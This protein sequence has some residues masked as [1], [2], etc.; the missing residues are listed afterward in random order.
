MKSLYKTWLL[1][2]LALTLPQM[3]VAYQIPTTPSGLWTGTGTTVPATP[4]TKD[5]P[6]GLRT[7]VSL[8]GAA[9]T[10]SA[11]NDVSLM[12]T[13]NTTVPLLPTN[14]NG[15]QVLATVGGGGCN[16]TSLTCT[17]LGTMTI[18]FSDTAGNPIRVRNPKLHLSRLGGSVTSGTNTTLLTDIFTLTT[19]GVTLGAPS[20]GAV[21]LSVTG[22][23]QV[24]ANLSTL[25]A[26]GVGACANAGC[27]TIPVT[28]TTSQLTFN[29][30]AVRNNTLVNWNNTATAGDAIFITASFDEDYGDAPASYDASSAASHIISDLAL[31]TSVTADNPDTA[32][33]GADGSTTVASSPNAVAAGANNNG[34]NGDGISDDGVSSFPALTTAA[35]ASYTVP[36]NLSGA[37]SAGQVCGWID[38]NKNTTFDSPSERACG[39]FASGATSAN[40]TWTV[41]AGVT[42][43]NTYVR[44]RASYDTAGVQNPT[45]RLNSGEVED[46]QIAIAPAPGNISG[47]LYQDANNDNTLT[48]G[49]TK[50]PA[51]VD[52]ELLNSAGTVIDTVQTNATGDYTFNNVP[53]ATGYQVR[54][55]TSDP[56]IPT[57]YAIGTT[58]P[59]TGINVTAG[60]TIANQNFGF[61][62]PDLT[63][64]K[65]HVGNFSK[66]GSNTY[67]LTATNSGTVATTGT[68]TL[69]DTLPTGLTPT[70][71]TGTGWNCTISGQVV[72]CTRSD[73]LA[74]N[75]S[76]P[77]ITLAVNVASTAP[78]SI[79]NTATISGGGQTNTANDSVNDPTTINPS[80]DL[81]LTKVVNNTSANVG[82]NVTFIVTVS[83]AG[84]D[85]ATGVSV[86]DLLPA[87]LT[88]VSATPSQGTYSNTT[89]VWSVGSVASATNATLQITVTVATAGAKTNTAQVTA[90]GQQDPDS[91]PNNSVA[92]ED[93][94]ASA[95]V[96]PSSTDLS[97]VKTDSPDPAIA[98]N[99]LTYAI[100]VTNTG[101]PATNVVMSDPL[102]AGTTFQ[103]ITS[104]AG[105]TCT[106][107]AVGSGGTVSCTAASLAVGTSN[108]T[109]VV[110]VAPNTAN[111]TTLSNTAT[112]SSATS[113]TNTSNN[114]ST[115]STTI[116]Q[117]ADL[118]LTKV[119]TPASPA[120]GDTFNYTIT[121]TNDGPSIATN[122]RVRDALPLGIG[123]V[124]NTP[125]QG[126]YDPL[127]TQVWNVGT[128][129]PGASATLTI[130]AIR[131]SAATTVNT[132]EV[133]GADQNDPDSP[134]NNQVVG[135][136]DQDSVTVPNQAVD[137]AVTKTVNNAT[138]SVG[139]N[140]TFTISVTN[141][142]ASTITAT[143]VGITDV[144]PQGLT[145]QSHNASTGA[146]NSSNGVWSI[147]SL[148]S[149]TTA[150]LT[151]VA[152]VT[153]SGAKT[154]T[155]QVSTLDQS[156]PNANND[157]GSATVTAAAVPPNLLLV[158]RITEVSG[159]PTSG[160]DDLT[161]GSKA[162]DDN[163]ANWPTPL[164]TYLRGLLNGG[165]IN[166][167]N[168]V[169][170][171]IYFLNNQNPATNVTIC[172]P[173]PANM[174][175]VS[176]G[177]NS[178]SPRPTE[179]G[180]LATDT[181][182]A[183]A[184]NAATLPTNPTFY[185]TNANDSDRG[186][187]YP[188]ND[189]ST[190]AACKR[191]NAAGSVTATGAA[192]NTDG[193]IVVNIVSGTTQLPSATTAGNPTNSYGFVRF[194]ARVK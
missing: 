115:Q 112:V 192:A 182:I 83:N 169:E 116:Q 129:N 178:A 148:T 36:V 171:T 156:D 128:L 168:E 189:P 163:N 43:G 4:A 66:G 1:A 121:V 40:L 73:V 111:N 42:A 164:A 141:P 105:W 38:F 22:G 101:S 125:S 106:T 60:A 49:E 107:P 97:I 122:V 63:I 89:G 167:G 176:N 35:G 132:A 126:T 85:S 136:D 69:S 91:T 93:D 109:V 108:F 51:N 47:S 123:Y 102:P 19:A 190:P 103:S 81:S 84:P 161:T 54:V 50:L 72:T 41:P 151:L 133:I 59:I 20:T 118:R 139:Q 70:A 95:T 175:F 180:A 98:G 86:A 25:T 76:Y 31:G 58:N 46:Y 140:V 120:V 172:D 166:P 29:V 100:A 24:Q 104:P 33:G 16:N 119:S 134:H 194:K 77:P 34:T 3:A 14:T 28:G 170:Y 174:T 26:T 193:A 157:S 80:A 55:V 88:F 39:S 181:G 143:N 8:T 155:A 114:S 5:T 99:N 62:T 6:S 17:G 56:Q 146:Y 150:T 188:P 152:Q 153:T 15:I 78:A 71:A 117:S 79:T 67:T 21:N 185:L 179:P 27:G 45:G 48:A 158:K 130:Q 74:A 138:A 9:M 23:N 149:G 30:S 65:T 53:V 90:S 162:A 44:L 10:F 75:T 173:I 142:A 165:S 52:V 68:V 186:R 64:T 12:R 13:N 2:L 184:S 7:T 92:T 87:G 145:Y 159:T 96:T 144:L 18:A 160:F 137:L 183:L 154:N 135:E 131:N 11:R 32:N 94:Q 57:G 177:Y 127:G 113:D 124:L 82:E 147:A 191:V 187:Y 61:R 37:S 110:R